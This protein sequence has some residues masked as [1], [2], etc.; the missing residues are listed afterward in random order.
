VSRFVAISPPSY[1]GRALAD[2]D[3]ATAPGVVEMRKSDM[4][5]YLC[6]DARSCEVL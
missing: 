5:K 4:G 6:L 2:G 3:A 1:S